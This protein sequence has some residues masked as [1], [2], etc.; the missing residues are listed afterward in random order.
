M[1]AQSGK[2]RDEA[3]VAVE[4]SQHLARRAGQ[5][6]DHLGGTAALMLRDHRGVPS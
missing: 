1:T 3:G 6:D 2:G 4:L 5:G